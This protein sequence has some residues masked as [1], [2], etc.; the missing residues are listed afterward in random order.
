MDERGY[1]MTRGIARAMYGTGGGSLG[2]I[3]TFTANKDISGATDTTTDLIYLSNPEDIVNF[4][5]GMYLTGTDA[6]ETGALLSAGTAFQVQDI[7]RSQGW[8]TVIGD[9]SAWAALDHLVEQSFDYATGPSYK[10]LRGLRA[11]CPSTAPAAGVQPSG[12]TG[13]PRRP[14]R[15]GALPTRTCT[16]RFR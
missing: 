11:W 14:R 2:I 3:G 12:T 8:L 15:P 13:P 9:A 6:A 7:D 1:E 5:V 10:E 4:E 16:G